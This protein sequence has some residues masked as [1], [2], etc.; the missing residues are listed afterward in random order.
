MF[1]PPANYFAVDFP[2]HAAPPAA[3]P[4]THSVMP[5]AMRGREANGSGHANRPF[6]RRELTARA[7]KRDFSTRGQSML[8]LGLVAT[9]PVLEYWQSACDPTAAEDFR[10]LM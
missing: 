9:W 6:E 2:A 7:G 1:S 5:R 3:T 10:S 4:V 8:A